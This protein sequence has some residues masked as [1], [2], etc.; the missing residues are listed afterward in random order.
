MPCGSSQKEKLLICPRIAAI[1]ETMTNNEISKLYTP[2]P[3][4]RPLWRRIPSIRSS[5]LLPKP[6]TST[7]KRAIFPSRDGSSPVSRKGSP[8]AADS[9]C[10]GGTGQAGDAAGSKHHQAAQYQRFDSPAEGRHRGTPGKGYALPDYPDE[11][12]NEEQKADPRTV[13]QGER[14]RR[15]SG[16]SRRQL[17]PAGAQKPS[18]STRERIRI[19]WANGRR[20]RRS[21]VA[22]MEGGDFRSNE[23]STDDCAG[24]H[25]PNRTARTGW[26]RHRARRR[27]HP[28]SRRRNRRRHNDEHP[29]AD[30]RSWKIRLKT[31]ESRACSSRFT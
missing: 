7:S 22:H 15:Q 18:R 12:A 26:Q 6:A 27:R 31:P 21:H 13:R 23:I 20:T 17:G 4:K 1:L 19:P 11:P 16:A 29:R 8:G 2:I 24:R 28:G 5:K 30:D 10:S 9:G 14:Q 3:M 25:S